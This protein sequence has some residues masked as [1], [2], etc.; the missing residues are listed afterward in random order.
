MNEKRKNQEEILLK[1]VKT[2]TT[3]RLS[4]KEVP[5]IKN[6]EI[7]KEYEVKLKLKQ[8]S[9]SEDDMGVSGNFEVVNEDGKK[10]AEDSEEDD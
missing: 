7:G 3:V 4:E 6:W 5:D 10:E 9:K 8:M 1:S 2:P